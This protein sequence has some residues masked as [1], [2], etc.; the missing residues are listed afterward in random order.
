MNF[1][2]GILLLCEVALGNSNELF[3]AD[4]EASRLP[5]KKNSVKGRFKNMF[6]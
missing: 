1:F 2:I 4:Y 5:K 6:S 3:H